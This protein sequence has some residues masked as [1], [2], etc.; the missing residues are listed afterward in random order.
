[1]ASNNTSYGA[2]DRFRGIFYDGANI[3][4]TR[5]NSSDNSGELWKLDG[6]GNVLQTIPIG[7]SPYYPAFDGRNIWVPNFGNSTVTVVRASDGSVLA[8]L[9]GNGLMAPVTAAFDG[10]RILVT[11]IGNH[12][13]S[14]WKATDLIP[15]GNFPI[16]DDSGPWGACSDGLKFWITLLYRNQLMQ[17]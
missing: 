2:F 5:Y 15:I 7:N 3:W 12:S 1:C 11:N 16:G 8:T 4:V 6:S 10:E 17:Y 14:L 9:S 13:V